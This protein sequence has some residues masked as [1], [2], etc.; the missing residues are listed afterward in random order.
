VETQAGDIAA[1]IPTN[2][3]SIT[4]GQIFLE[5]DLF[6]GGQ[7]PAMN[8]GV[9]V[10]R[11]GGDAQV[12]AMKQ[13]AG[14]LRLELAQY[15]ELSAFSQFASDLDATTRRQ[16]E[17]GQRLMRVMKQNV[18]EPLPVVKQVA[19]IYAG[20]NGYLD[21]VPANR[22]QDFEARLFEALDSRHAETVAL[23]NR[24]GALDPDVKAGLERAI[25]DAKGLTA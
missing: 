1:Y 18:H 11:V 9:S 5:T 20:V 14:F 8:P 2:V 13:S 17:R 15:R 25:K 4:D 24:K 12:K 7:R 19:I 16:L 3:I 23:F 6:N 21:D 10:S 22:I